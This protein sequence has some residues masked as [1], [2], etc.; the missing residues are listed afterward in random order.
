MVCDLLDEDQ[1]MPLKDKNEAR[2][3]KDRFASP[4]LSANY[5]GTSIFRKFVLPFLA[6]VVIILATTFRYYKPNSGFVNRISE[7]FRGKGNQ[8]TSRKRLLSIFAVLAMCFAA[9]TPNLFA[10]GSDLGTIRGLVTDSSGALVP[11]AQVKITNLDNLRDYLYKTDARG[12]YDAPNL[13]P[14]QYKAEISAPGFETNVIV[15][16]VLNGSDVAQENGV[17]HPASQT[18]NV[19]VTSQAVGINMDNQTLSQTFNPLEIIDLPRDSRD[20]NTF[21][22]LDPSVTN[23][24]SGFKAIGTQGYGFNFSLDG[25][26]NSGGVGGGVTNSEP[27][28]EA[29][30]E[31]NVLSSSFSA[32]YAGVLNIRVNTKDG[33]ATNHGSLFYNN[34]NGALAAESF[35]AA[36][37]VRSN[38]TEFGGSWGGPIPLLKKTFFFMAFEAQDSVGPQ[39]YFNSTGI[40]SP[41]V[42]SGNFSEV[43]LCSDPTLASI[44]ADSPGFIAPSNVTTGTCSTNHQTVVTGVTKPNP[45]T[46]ELISLYFPQNVPDVGVTSTTGRIGPTNPAYN[47]SYST[48]NTQEFGDLRIDHD[49]NDSNRIYGV[50]HGRANDSPGG[51][52]SYPYT[53]LGRNSTVSENYVLSLSYTHVFTSH[54]INEARGGFNTQDSVSGDA[55]TV[56]KFLQNIGFSPTDLAAYGNAIGTA[57][58]NLLGNTNI[59]F[60]G[61]IT[62][63]GDAARNAQADHTEHLL[64][65]GDTVSWQKGHHSLRIG[66]DFVRDQALDSFAALRN[67]P[68]STLVYSG[69]N[70]TGFT[71]FL[72]GNAAHTATYVT[73]PR[74]PMDA[75]NWQTSYYV[76]DDDRI[77]KRLTLNLGFRYDRNTPYTD[78]NDIMANFDPNFRDSTTGQIGR[79]IVPSMKT[80]Q[81]MQSEEYSAPPTGI[82]YVLAANSGLGVGRGLVRPDRFDFGPRFGWAYRITDKQVFRGGIG[83]YYPDSTSHGIRDPLTTNAFNG[84][85]TFTS[86]ASGSGH[87]QLD[88][89]PSSSN[90]TS[91]DAPVVGGYQTSFSNYPTANWVPVNLKNPRLLA[92]NATFEQQLPWQTTVRVSYI[93]A[94]QSGQIIGNDLDMIQANDNPF[95]TT[96][97]ILTNTP[98]NAYPLGYAGQP[99][100]TGLYK[101]CDPLHDGDCAYSAADNARVEFP[102][103]GDYVIGFGNH[104]RSMTNSLQVQ[105][106]RKAKSLTY[107]VSYTYLDQKSSVADVGTDS[108]GG[109]N[110]NPFNKSFDY[111][112]DSFVSTHRLVAFAVYDLPF[113]RGKSY[114]ANMNKVVDS[115]AGGWQLS[116]N[117]FIK[118]GIGLTPHWSC[119]DCDPVMP[120]NIASADEDAIG[121]FTAT[122]FRPNIANN[123]YARP[124]NQHQFA[125]DAVDGVG[126][127][128]ASSAFQPPDVGSTYWTNPTVA[129]RNAL[130][131][132][133]TWGANLGVHKSFQVNH[134]IAVK[135]GADIDNVFNHPMHSPGAP[136]SFANIGTVQAM[137]PTSLGLAGAPA[138]GANLPAGV[139]AVGGGAQPAVQPFT[140]TGNGTGNLS[141]ITYNSAFGLKNFSTGQ[142]GIGANRSIRLIGRITF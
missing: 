109:A 90:D 30:G 44:T 120:G 99:A 135:I 25:Q 126:N 54:L 13:I 114:G 128:T 127:P 16:I 26:R 83:L 60:G 121:D 102:Q 40:L 72:L 87:P 5:A 101:A 93:G 64:T 130:T 74:P 57:A 42:Q 38:A 31:L 136:D 106:E 94:A 112:R 39:N 142:E 34:E 28:L 81:Y 48:S 36:K 132:P 134:R 133:S 103:L 123:P 24:S 115:F 58:I 10:Q 17:L 85:A 51:F 46:A 119:G 98:N 47:Q 75:Y 111:T 3:S 117:G 131:G 55:I 11:N 122:T 100:Y 78:K 137:N 67:T 95:G 70:L 32:E 35:N 1:I 18:V 71:N 52:V 7:L 9:Y 97:G 86:G 12:G 107:S 8:V 69:S 73:L 21:V 82:G 27:S 140:A 139:G 84:K 4:Y 43:A 105:A 37:K 6:V 56:S 125:V 15:G 19:E 2:Q 91:G 20:I 59:N 96:Q 45:I 79:Y 22:Y 50:Y 53:G 141:T 76:Q 29:V 49:F 108:L 14:G 65:F 92:W 61:G 62:T 124:D 63:M 68:E 138:D 89:W 129:R 77:N 80:V 88:P 110:Y 116:T 104:G 41:L 23:G 66:A 33:G 118:S 113:G